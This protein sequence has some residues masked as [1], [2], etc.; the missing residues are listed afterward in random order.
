MSHIVWE[1][2]YS[3]HIEVI[4]E[5]H[6]H[7]FEVLGNLFDGM[8]KGGTR[9]I[10]NITLGELVQYAAEHFA[11]EEIF[12]TQYDFPGYKEHKQE[13]ETFKSKVAAFQKDFTAGKAMLS[14]EV[15]NFLVS[16]LD[17][18]ILHIDKKYSPFLN[19]KGIY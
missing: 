8:G 10:L 7:L 15:V 16:W 9:E 6:K 19:E 17:H 18:H 5:Q 11:T 2:K 1:E 3:V 12:M 14:A 13:H 4:D